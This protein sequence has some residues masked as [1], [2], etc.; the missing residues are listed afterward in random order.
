[1]IKYSPICRGNLCINTVD[2][3]TPYCESCKHKEVQNELNINSVNNILTNTNLSYT[4]NYSSENFLCN[5]GNCINK[6]FAS[7]Y[8]LNRHQN[9]THSNVQ[10]ECI[11]C[12]KKFKR[13]DA[14]KKHKEVVHEKIKNYQCLTCLSKFASLKDLNI[15]IRG[16]HLKIRAFTCNYCPEKLSSTQSKIRHHISVHSNDMNKLF[17]CNICHGRFASQSPLIKHIKSA[18][19]LKTT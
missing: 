18:H 14:L 12:N 4:I 8:H 13:K 1:M 6:T 5:M 11:Q 10:Y 19:E 16:V 17:E 9:T 15:H 3:D 2:I 7:R